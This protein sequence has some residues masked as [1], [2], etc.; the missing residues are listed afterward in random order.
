MVLAAET[1]SGKTLAY[2]APVLHLALA[3]RAQ[4]PQP[5]AEAAPGSSR[6]RA[7]QHG[8]GHVR[9][10]AALVLCPN[11]VLCEQVRWTHLG[12]LL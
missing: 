10:T 12:P 5:A 3:S 9:P 6:S 7:E 4:L 2:L 11:A 8:H 1:G